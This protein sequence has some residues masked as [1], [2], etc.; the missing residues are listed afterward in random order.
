MMLPANQLMLNGQDYLKHFAKPMNFRLFKIIILSPIKNVQL[1]NAIYLEVS[2]QIVHM[3]LC[4]IVQFNVEVL[5]NPKW[6]IFANQLL[7]T[8]RAQNKEEWSAPIQSTKK[9]TS[10][11]PQ[12]EIVMADKASI[13]SK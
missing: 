11:K 6:I 3:L 5:N 7:A 12:P 10:T 9:K 4:L 2:L 8:W 1:R 13:M